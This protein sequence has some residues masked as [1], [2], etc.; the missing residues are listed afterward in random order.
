MAT[1]ISG[2]R[3]G[4]IGMGRIGKVI[5]KRAAGF[6]MEVR[7]HNREAGRGKSLGYAASAVELAEWCDFSGE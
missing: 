6:D 5:A 4:I 3:L 1:R 7:Y 2:K